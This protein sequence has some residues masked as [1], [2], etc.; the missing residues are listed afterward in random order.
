MPPEPPR[1]V[2]ALA[3][4]KLNL[5]LRV[6]GRRPDGYHELAS[7]FVGVSLFDTLTFRARP[8]GDF[9]L[10]L[11]GG[12]PDVPAGADNLVLRAASAMR[13]AAARRGKRCGGADITLHKRIPSQAGL[14]GGSSDA[15]AAVLAL[16]RLC[17]LRLPKEVLHEVA[18]GLGSDVN[19]FV[20][21]CRSAVCTGRGEIVR[22]TDCPGLQWFT[23]LKPSMSAATRDVFSA[24]SANFDGVPEF[25]P[26]RQFG[27]N[28]KMD[29][30][31]KRRGK[32]RNAL[33]TPALQTTTGL[34]DWLRRVK[35]ATR[36]G[37]W[38]MTGSGTGFFASV[39]TRRRARRLVRMAAAADGP[40]RERTRA[41][42]ASPACV[43]LLDSAT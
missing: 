31:G 34:D 36:H 7:I 17:G 21:G 32:F 19:F 6:L 14:G 30:S 5:D 24:F 8:D 25:R 11:R 18:A 41:Y 13:E 26:Y 4:A 40:N 9:R 10:T 23:I 2:T 33:Q 20:E 42:V 22:A 28:V 43:R 12:P 38:R 1:V 37:D 39:A 15:A 27:Q 35:A 29:D 3:P 16:N